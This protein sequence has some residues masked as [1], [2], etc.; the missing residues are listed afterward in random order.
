MG[1]CFVGDAAVA[2]DLLP[3]PHGRLHLSAGSS[4]P[5]QY[6]GQRVTFV[7]ENLT[8]STFFDISHGGGEVQFSAGEAHRIAGS[9]HG[10][11]GDTAGPGQVCLPMQQEVDSGTQRKVRRVELAAP[12]VK[13][14]LEKGKVGVDWSTFGRVIVR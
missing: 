11:R 9:M 3:A 6:W 10:C 12:I 2:D 1:S 8:A 13:F 14:A 4:T 5:L 7:L